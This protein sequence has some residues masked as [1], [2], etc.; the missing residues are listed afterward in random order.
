MPEIAKSKSV[1]ESIEFLKNVKV[2]SCVFI[3]EQTA[4]IL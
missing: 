3:E 2:L 4:G 1:S